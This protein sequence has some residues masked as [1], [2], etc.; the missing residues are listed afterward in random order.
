MNKASEICGPIQRAPIYMKLELQRE[1][2]KKMEDKTLDNAE[3]P[4]LVEHL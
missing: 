1:R 2:R 3:I 4:K